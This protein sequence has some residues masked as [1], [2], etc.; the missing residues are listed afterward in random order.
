[1]ERISIRVAMTIG[2]TQKKIY[3]MLYRHR[4]KKLSQIPHSGCSYESV[5]FRVVLRKEGFGPLTLKICENRY[6]MQILIEKICAAKNS[7]QKDV[8]NLANAVY[9]FCLIC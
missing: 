8:G 9:S 2:N 4:A 1:M 5:A 7:L 3:E 6:E